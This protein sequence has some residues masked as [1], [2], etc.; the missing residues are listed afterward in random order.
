[1]VFLD[2]HG[3]LP[4]V[5]MHTCDNPRC[6]N[7]AHLKAGTTQDNVNDRVAKG[8]SAKAVP[9]RY[10]VSPAVRHDI[11][12]STRTERELAEIYGLS[13]STVHYIRAGRSRG[14]S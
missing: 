13:P 12:H 14:K 7:P 9:S 8:R 4:E 6:I 10:K 5:V 11:Q 2:T 1:M 3:Y